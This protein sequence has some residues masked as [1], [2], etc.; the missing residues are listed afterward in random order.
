MKKILT[1]LALVLCGLVSLNAVTVSGVAGKYSGTLKVAEDSQNGSIIILPGTEANKV[2]LV[3]P[4]FDFSG[5]NLG[6]IVVLNADFASNGAIS[7]N[8]FPVYISALSERAYV[9]INAGS[10][11][12]GNSVTLDL[13]IEVPSLGEGF[14][15]V[16]FNGSRTQGNYQMPNA[17]F[18]DNWHS[19][20][21]GVEPN[22]W[23][24]FNSGTGAVVSAAQNNVQLNESNEVRPGSTGSKS[25]LLSSKY[26]N[27]FITKVKANGNLTNGQINAAGTSADDGT[28]NFNFSDPSNSGF[29]TPFTAL[30]D[31]FVFWAKYLPADG[32]VSSS[33][34]RARAHA[35]I[36]T[37]AYYKDP[38]DGGNYSSVK[39]ADA[40]RNYSAT[41]SK[42][43]QRVSIPFNYSST[44]NADNAAYILITFSTNQNAGGGTS[45]K[46]AEDHIYLDDVEMIYN[47]DL[48]NF[49]IDGT[50]IVFNNGQATNNKPFSDEKYNCQATV[51]GRRSDAFV[52]YDAANECVV[53]YTVAEDFAT[54]SSD[55]KIYKVQMAPAEVTGLDEVRVQQQAQKVMINGHVYIIRNGAWYDT[56]GKRVHPL[57]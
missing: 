36:T 41:A 25:A 7:I 45:S 6:D 52:G 43:W 2:T 51:N 54:N 5:L 33:E 38:E 30:P 48:T 29:N 32:N 12:N 23:H 24:S 42:G 20:G 14:L 39:V 3:L 46:D 26:T 40:E 15:P 44:V 34:N 1:T 22:Y 35:V 16:T 9:T 50:N 37:N 27:Y 55:Y 53:V 18:E 49:K 11:L 21:K 47:H 10:V 19:V 17:G 28:K 56:L 57:R 4:D 31:S 8:H 13:G